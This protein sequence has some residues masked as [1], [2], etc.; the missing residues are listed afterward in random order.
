MNL[1]KVYNSKLKSTLNNMD[2]I[3]IVILSTFAAHLA[4]LI[5]FLTLK[6]PIMVI[7]NIFSLIIYSISLVPK[8]RNDY[9]LLL[10]IFYTEILF[11]MFSATIFIG[12][13]SGFSLY[14]FALIPFTYFVSYLS[15]AKSTSAI[16]TKRYSLVS[17]IA[18][19]TLRLLTYFEV[20]L[21]QVDSSRILHV[22]YMIN[23]SITIL[24]VLFCLSVF[25]SKITFSEKTLK[26]NNTRLSSLAITDPLTGFYNRRFMVDHLKHSIRRAEHAGHHFSLLL[27][28]IDDFKQ[29]NDTHGHD[30]GDQVIQKMS[31]IMSQQV[32]GSDYICRWGG[33]EVLILLPECPHED[34]AKLAEKLRCEI[35]KNPIIYRDKKISYS[36]TF[37][38]QA[39]EDCT[40]YHDLIKKADIK[41]YQ[42]KNSGKNCVVS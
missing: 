39:Y 26:A 18:F 32:R 31:A 7:I 23:S 22:V 36:M 15:S 16:N 19:L 21:Y 4:A 37:G 28:D 38:V 42:G 34:A 20:P 29:I 13:D 12:W 2:H 25:S 41:L 10:K 1:L 8:I 5:F 11:F 30:C 9:G 24:F 14:T 27:C 3:V 40:D 33:E 6:I 17:I 35:H